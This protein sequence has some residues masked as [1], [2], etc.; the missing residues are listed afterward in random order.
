M[1]MNV[2]NK[3]AWQN[4]K[5]NRARTMITIAGGYF[6]NGAD[7]RNTLLCHFDAKLYGFGRS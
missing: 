5:R 7:Y 1:M 2:F 3:I 6:I 4:L